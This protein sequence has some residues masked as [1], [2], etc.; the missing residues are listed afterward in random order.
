MS[1]RNLILST[2]RCVSCSK[3][4]NSFNRSIPILRRRFSVSQVMASTND[5][6]IHP[7]KYPQARRDETIVD[8][9]LGRKV[10]DPYRWLEDPDAKETQDFV[11]QLNAI[12]E[13]FLAASP[14]REKM[15]ERLTKLWDYEK[16]GCTSIHG[17]F[18]YYYY[19]SGLQNQL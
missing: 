12:S 18:Y 9:F 3:P 13:P 4:S 7:G 15:R 10:A 8:E 2:A 5:V 17:D 19:N 1:F 6:S 14:V 11:T 16:Y